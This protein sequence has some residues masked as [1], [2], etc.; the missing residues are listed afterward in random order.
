M[1]VKCEN[2]ELIET[3]VGRVVGNF[4]TLLDYDA[5]R[6]WHCE[7]SERLVQGAGK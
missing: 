1:I 3:R 6:L 4:D 5:Q 7:R 2:S